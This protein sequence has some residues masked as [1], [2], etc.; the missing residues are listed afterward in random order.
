MG[1]GYCKVKAFEETFTAKLV[2]LELR[3][4]NSMAIKLSLRI[5][6]GWGGTEEFYRTFWTYRLACH[7]DL[8]AVVDKKI[9]KI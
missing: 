1:K 3:K 4:T 9:V 7:A 8:P 6:Y 2:A 5:K